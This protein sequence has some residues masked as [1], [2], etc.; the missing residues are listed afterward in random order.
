M[1]SEITRRKMLRM[2]CAAIGETLLSGMT[3]EAGTKA[4]ESVPW[5]GGLLTLSCDTCHDNPHLSTGH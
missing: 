1:K 2:G 4:P 3:A 5:A